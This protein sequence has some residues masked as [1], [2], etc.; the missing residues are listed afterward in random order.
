[1]KIN[2]KLMEDNFIREDF[3]NTINLLRK[4]NSILTQSKYVE[5]FE[6][7]WSK[8]LGVK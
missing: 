6:K 1:M 5:L 4:K 8:W 2:H 7:K 3:T